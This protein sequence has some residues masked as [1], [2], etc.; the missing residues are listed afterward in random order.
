MSYTLILG[1][2]GTVGRALVQTLQQ[3]GE[4][5]LAG[6][7]QPRGA[8]TLALDLATGAG[9]EAAFA[10]ASRAF[11]MSPPGHPDQ[12]AL[13]GPAV[14]AARRQGVSKLVL[15]TAMGAD[16]DPN[17]PFRRLEQ[18]VERAGLAYNII[19]PN[20]FMQNFTSYW[21]PGIL[22]RGAI[23]LPTGQ[24]RGSF[25]DARDIADVAA[26][27]L[28]TRTHDRQAFDLTGAEAFDHQEVAAL[29]SAATGRA[30]RY[31]DIPPDAMRA[32]LLAAGMPA[33]YAE[34]LVAILGHFKAG[35]AERVTDAVQTI[36]GRPPRS[37]QAFVQEHAA[38]WRPV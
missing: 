20:W 32:G 12:D 33:G 34:M 28:T 7:R 13:L 16:A 1:G 3:R 15:M 24:G 6:A 19:R 5:V 38:V 30:I 37:L 29:L 36:T 9:L 35:A 21:L 26:V 14:D 25:I 10:G 31:E 27:L 11:L 23:A 22:E 2:T 8:D 18:R 17:G 4:R